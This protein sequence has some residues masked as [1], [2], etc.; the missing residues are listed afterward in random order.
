MKS[1]KG[2]EEGKKKWIHICLDSKRREG[3]LF[4]GGHE[5]LKGGMKLS[6][7]FCCF[8]PQTSQSVYL[9]LEIKK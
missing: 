8:P 1:R 9:H 6:G 2:K 4:R 5:M 7:L 3:S